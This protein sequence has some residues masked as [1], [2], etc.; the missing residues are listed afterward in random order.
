MVTIRDILEI[1][2]LDLRLLAGAAA[3]DAPVR[4]VVVADAP[5]STASLKG[6]ELLLTHGEA[7]ADCVRRPE[8]GLAE[9]IGRDV[10]GVGFGVGHTHE[11]V[12]EGLLAGAEA[13]G[14]PL[15]EVPRHIPLSALAEVVTTKIVNA[16]YSL[17]QRSAAVHEKLTTL[18]LEEK[19]IDAVTATLA[20]LARCSCTLFGFHGEVLSQ[21]SAGAGA[22]AT[23]PDMWRLVAN[24]RLSR[25]AFSFPLDSGEHA[26]VVPV[27][28]AHRIG[29]FLVVLKE[30]TG[31]G[32]YE[33]LI[34]HHAVT[35]V[36]LELVKRRAVSRTKQR[37]V[38]DF[39]DQLVARRLSEGEI[40]RQLTFFGL[41]PAASRVV[42]LVDRDDAGA[43]RGGEPTER[44]DEATSERLHWAA[45]EVAAELG[46]NCL[47]TARD[48]RVVLVIELSRDGRQDVEALARAL[49]EAAADVVPGGSVSVGIGRPHESVTDLRRSYFEAY[50]ALRLRRLRGDRGAV[51]DHRDL[52]SY[53]LLLG[54]QDASSL[55]VFCESVLGRLRRHDDANAGDLVAS[56]EA[57]LESN[58]HWGDA[59]E[60]LYVHRHTLRYRMRRVEEIT[61]RDL[62]EPQ[63]RMEF[64]LA[65][66]AKQ[67]VEEA[68]EQTAP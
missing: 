36:A 3:T 58:G 67:F 17:L 64:W 9:I 44:E 48:S 54:L 62:D 57:F 34:V 46:F 43:A 59:A 49:L 5:S 40:A 45:D 66:K 37:L 4:W 13:A 47:T 63:D 28:V 24:Q 51:A 42:V 55:E 18:L 19:G 7:F 25:T 29:A 30:G 14:L 12:P 15:F 11:R 60:K 27:M 31:F 21:A 20:T 61:G 38:G 23:G 6:G 2:D 26:L 50:Y 41:D 52:G 33:R 39:L 68:R 10:V 65:L 22:A 32:D 8:E 56:L 53:S 1:P 16:Q 35:A